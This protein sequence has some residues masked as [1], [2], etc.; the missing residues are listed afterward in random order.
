MRKAIA[1]AALAVC[2]AS[3]A[4]AQHEG[5]RPSG[6]ITDS[7]ALRSVLDLSTLEHW[8]VERNAD[9]DAARQAYQAALKIPGTT[10]PIE[11]PCASAAA[12][13][14]TALSER[15]LDLE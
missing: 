15:G 12:I 6:A 13:C 9:V 1:L 7:L 3:P 4:L 5:M 11:S 14:A 8:V 2:S 10:S